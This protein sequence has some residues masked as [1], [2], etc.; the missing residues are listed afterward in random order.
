MTHRHSYCYRFIANGVTRQGLHPARGA[1]ERLHD[2]ASAEL[3][4]GFFHAY[5][6]AA[7]SNLTWFCTL[8]TTCTSTTW[9]AT[10]TQW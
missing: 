8:A 4:E 7:E 6:G 2:G 9:A 1:G 10:Q 3:P 5:H